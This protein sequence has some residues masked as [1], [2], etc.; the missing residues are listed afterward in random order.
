M[1]GESETMYAYFVTYRDA[2]RARTVAAIMDEAQKSRDYGWKLSRKWNW[3]RRAEAWDQELDR[4]FAETVA[5]RRRQAAEQVLNVTRFARSKIAARVTTLDWDKLN[6]DQLLR[7][8]EVVVRVERDV[9]GEPTKVEVTG[10][11]GGPVQMHVEGM[12]D[13]ERAAYARRLMQ[14]AQ[15][16]FGID[17]GSQSDMLKDVPDSLTEEDDGNDGSG[18][19]GEPGPADPEGPAA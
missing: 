5:D 3:A 14:E 13:V 19:T 15:A 8:L 7:W 1:S 18:Q 9:M 11:G 2:G 12:S 4:K 6:A 16:R 17:P 10:K